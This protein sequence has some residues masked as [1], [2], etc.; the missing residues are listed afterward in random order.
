MVRFLRLPHTLFLILAA[1][2]TA[3][4]ADKSTPPPVPPPPV[5]PAPLKPSPVPAPAYMDVSTFEYRADAENHKVVVTRSPTLARVDLPDEGYSFLYDPQTDYYTGLEH[6]NYT[7]WEFSWPDV[8]S[9]IEGSKRYE[10]R[11]QDLGSQTLATDSDDTSTN[12]DTTTNAAPDD[13]TVGAQVGSDGYIWRPT[14]DKKRISDLDCIR[15]TG[16]SLS[17]QNM[18]AW[19]YAGPVPM[20]QAAIDTLRK[21]NEPMALVP[22]RTIVPDAIFPAYDALVKGGVMPILITWGEKRNQSHFRFVE[23]KTQN[24]RLALFTVPKL[25]VRTTLV[26]LDGLV[27]SQ[28]APGGRQGSAST[29]TWQ[30]PTGDKRL[31][32]PPAMSQ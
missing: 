18:E 24:G 27:D 3:L 22:I 1:P 14:I 16:E 7:Y 32:Q 23:A 19:C 31:S 9:Q 17:G 2:F 6:K 12:A 29:N 11:L 25:Y 10:K 13:S 5:M 28:P 8:R 26:T 15:W 20:A 30:N 4:A 21:V